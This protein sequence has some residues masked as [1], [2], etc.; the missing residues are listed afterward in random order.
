M[1]ASVDP[2]FPDRGLR[3]SAAAL[4]PRADLSTSAPT[5]TCSAAKSGFGTPRRLRSARARSIPQ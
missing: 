3:A 5:R 1:V 4:R 2:R